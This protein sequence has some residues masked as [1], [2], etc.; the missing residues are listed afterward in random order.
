VSEFKFLVLAVDSLAYDCDFLFKCLP[1]VL[2][3]F[4]QL[5]STNLLWRFKINT[6]SLS[7]CLDNFGFF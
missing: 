7:C 2:L 1:V 3:P 6:M 4:F 5:A